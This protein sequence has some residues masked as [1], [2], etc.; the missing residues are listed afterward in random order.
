MPSA[1]HTDIQQWQRALQSAQK[2]RLDPSEIP[3]KALANRYKASP[4]EVADIVI[5]IH[6][7]TGGDFVDPLVPRYINHLLR[8]R[9]TDSTSV[10]LMLLKH[11]RFAKAAPVATSAFS[12]LPSFEQQVFTLLRELLAVAH[13]PAATWKAHGVVFALTRW[14]HVARKANEHDVGKQLDSGVMHAGDGP[15]TGTFEALGMLAIAVFGHRSFPD[16]EKQP[17]WKTRRPQVAAEMEQYDMHVLQWI[18]SQYTGHLQALTKGRPFL[19]TD[20]QGRPKFTDQQIL[21]S[22][23]EVP[24][25]NTR[26]GLF[27]WLSA[28]LCARPLTDDATM[29]NYLLVRYSDNAQTAAVDLVIAAFDVLTNACLRKE[30]RPVIKAIRSFICNKLLILLHTLV[31]FTGPGAVDGCV[32]MAMMAVPMD[33]LTPLSTGATDVRAQLKKVRHE[34]LVACALQGLISEATVSGVLQEH[35]VT[36]PKANKYTKEGLVAQCAHN[37]GK[38][39]SVVQELDAVQGNAGAISGCIVDTVNNL[40]ASK[41]TMALKTVCNALLRKVPNL[42]IVMQYTQP[43]TLLLP[44]CNT[45]NEWVHDQDQSEFQPPYEEFACILLLLLAAVHRYDLSISD[46]GLTQ[47]DSFITKLLKGISHSMQTSELSDEQRQQLSKWIEGLYATDE[48]GETTGI[49]DEVMS[50]CPPQAFYLLVPTLFEQSVLACKMNALSINTAKGGLEFLLEPFLLP[51]LVGGLT[52][53]VKHS[54]EDH[55]DADILLQILDKLLKPSSTAQEMQVMHR[56]IL[57]IVAEPLEKSLQELIRRRSDKRKEASELV[58][59]LKPYLCQQRTLSSSKA[60]LES[61]AAEGFLVKGVRNTVRDMTLWAAAAGSGPPPRYT[62]RIFHAAAQIDGTE[63][64]LQAIMD[65]LKDQAMF[66]NASIALDI[67]TALIC[68]PEPASHTPLMNIGTA[69][70]SGAQTSLTLRDMVRLRTADVQMLQELPVDHA[71]TLVRLARR[72]EAQSAVSQ[73]ALVSLP[74]APVDQAVA[75]QVMKDLGL[76]ADE[77]AAVTDGALLD[78]A[79]ALGSNNGADFNAADF[80]AATDQP[81]DLTNGGQLDLTSMMD[82][83]S[84]MQMDHSGNTFADLG[85]DFGQSG[86]ASTGGE[87]QNDEQ[88]AEDDIFAGLDLGQD[89]DFS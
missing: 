35:S 50:H 14:L 6:T 43:A 5:R 69:L 39:E 57:A 61:F 47:D 19:E 79:N 84:M 63:V 18:Q 27:L 26:A 81:L 82:D 41:D 40:C 78:T 1:T 54:W 83:S 56:A 67:A 10:M 55:D 21:D 53:L 38:L 87:G 28:C 32:Q 30:P 33:P 65:E 68:A 24:A 20:E 71:E 60:E 75:D 89:F 73:V 11:S 12:A 22:V 70:Q 2:R 85:M 7:D 48:H 64:V 9:H 66:G 17:W 46:V 15:A 8:T 16:I 77:A 80:G 76:S 36:L 13:F 86:G 58:E 42:D 51:S 34:F 74:A 44:L 25:V 4:E 59:L 23:S 31:G 72:I 88:N 37:T 3:L 49:G 45:L 29:R 62:P 52:W